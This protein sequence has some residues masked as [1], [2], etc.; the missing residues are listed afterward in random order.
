V[1]RLALAAWLVA[2]LWLAG[3]ATHPEDASTFRYEGSTD[4]VPWTG[5]AFDDGDAFTFALFSDLTGGER[6]GV[7]EVAVAQ[8]NLLRPEFV[9][10]VGDLIEGGTTDEA[11]LAREW[12]SFDRRAGA[13][14]ARLFYT[15][16][17]HDLTNPA[18][19]AVYE[20]R[21]GAR[22]Y[23]FLYKDTLFLVLD[24]EDNTAEAQWKLHE[25]REQAMA[26]VDAEGWG[27]FGETE[28]GRSPARR[29]GRVGEAQADYFVEVIGRNP[30]VRHT[31]VILHKAVWEQDAEQEFARV[32]A[33]LADR[34]YTV[35][36]G[37][38]HAYLHETRQG[39]DYIR[40]GTTGGVQNPRKDMAIDHVSLVTV[41]ETGVD[42]ANLR[43]S[44]IFGK[45]GRI[46]L[47]GED[48]CF[49]V[50]ACT[51]Q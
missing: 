41:S 45:D 38:E 30:G 20:R 19:W 3:C 1:R 23:H 7:F 51:G 42:I 33:A 29:H 26:A 8:L 48:L 4:A 49:D 18:M 2:A 22:Y 44:G 11:Q 32:E 39:R 9:I 35:F 27:V 14:R 24:T 13:A 40:L 36:Y 34:P 15:G 17:N 47:D 43:L 10:G 28:Y 25:I 50:R 6:P 5:R 37:H 21:Y 46:P 16:G 31:F 12:D